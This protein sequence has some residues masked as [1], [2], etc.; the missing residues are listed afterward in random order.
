MIAYFSSKD[1]AI[2]AALAFA[3]LRR[4]IDGPIRQQHDP[5]LMEL[6]KEV[7]NQVHKDYFLAELLEQGIPFN[8]CKI[9][10]PLGAY[11]TMMHGIYTPTE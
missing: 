9:N 4:K 11:S 3:R 5:E 8:Y 7:R 2:N 1:K 6:A 10:T